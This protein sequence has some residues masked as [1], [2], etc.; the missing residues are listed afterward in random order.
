MLNFK[1]LITFRNE[2]PAMKIIKGVLMDL[3]TPVNISNFWN[4]GS[5]LG[6]CLGLQL[7]SGLFLASHYNSSPFMA[8]DSVEHI[9]KDV[10]MGWVFRIVHLNGA[11]FFFI[12][13][14]MHIARGLYYKSY[15]YLET[16][17]LG[18]FIF[19]FSMAIAFLGYV[20]PW[21]QMSFWGATVITNLISAIP[22]IGNKVVIWIWGAYSVSSPTLS[23]FF[24]LHFC[25]P[26][27]LAAMVILHIFF[28]HKT[29]SQN[30]SNLKSS[31]NLI[32]FHW[33]LSSKDIFFFFFWII[34][35][36]FLIFLFPF[37]LGD[38]EN[39]ILANSLS[40]PAHIVPE[41]YF[42]FA[43]AILRSIP[44][45]LGG[46]IALLLSVLI[47]LFPSLWSLNKSKM[48]LSNNL[49]KFLSKSKSMSL[50]FQSFSWFFL[51]IFL[52]L[53]WIGGEV[54]EEPF[55]FIGQAFLILYF[56]LFL[57]FIL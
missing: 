21:G 34:L 17:N 41:W 29:G 20:L 15:N 5:C 8:F 26:F 12:F 42:L 10:S 27:V 16:W 53:T 37:L 47:L 55:I 4:F 13:L 39:F 57:L 24:M 28:L 44:S 50:T 9:M 33:F 7:V 35:L 32:S 45:K 11:S 54:V 56:L 18:V 52:I 6:A 36:E 46:V 48:S 51:G 49:L 30:P 2:N 1:E 43:Y 31:Y 23:R 40:T 14:F 25:L 19:L 38:P 3:P 22:I